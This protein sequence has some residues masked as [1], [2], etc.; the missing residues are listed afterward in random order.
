MSDTL[1]RGGRPAYP[2]EQRRKWSLHAL[3]TV[4]EYDAFCVDAIRAR[5]TLSS[6]IRALLVKA[7]SQGVTLTDKPQGP[8]IV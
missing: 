4:S 1:N 6:Y 2:E 5:M 8:S 7:R 3:V